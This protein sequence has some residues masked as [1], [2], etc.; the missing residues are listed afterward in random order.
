MNEIDELST[1][2]TKF[3]KPL[4]LHEG[5][6]KTI[7]LRCAYLK[8]KLGTAVPIGIS[9]VKL[10]LTSIY[11]YIR[12]PRYGRKIMGHAKFISF[13]HELG[14]DLTH[15]DLWRYQKLYFQYG[16]YLP[17]TNAKDY[18]EAAWYDISKDL[19]LPETAKDLV[20]SLLKKVQGLKGRRRAPGIVVGTAIYLVGKKIGSHFWQKELAEYF[21]IS[22][23]S[24]RNAKDDFEPCMNAI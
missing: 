7:L 14:F 24:L 10:L 18:F 2:V 15:K 21:G 1:I 13:C 16:Y 23:V 19:G 4:R 11:C 8:Q 9:E 12:T 5:D 3:Q 22:E 6:A 20:L 17:I